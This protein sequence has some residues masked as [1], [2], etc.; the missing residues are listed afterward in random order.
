MICIYIYIYLYVHTYIYIYRPK[1]LKNSQES[2]FLNIPQYPQKK[3]VCWFNMLQSS[4]QKL[5]QGLVN[6]P[7]W[8]YWT[9]PQKVAIINHIPNGWVMWNM[10]TWL[11]T[12]VKRSLEDAVA[13]QLWDEPWC[14]TL[15]L[16]TA[17]LPLAM[18]IS[19]VFASQTRR[20]KK[21]W[22]FTSQNRYC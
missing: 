3:S 4:S 17:P 5:K 19:R 14:Q 18:W 12:H 9:S 16:A 22:W 13:L 10:G 21:T 1:C 7:F 2:F 20:T 11:M 15:G 8:E 6:V